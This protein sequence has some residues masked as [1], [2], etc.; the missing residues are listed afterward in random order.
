M[1]HAK[2]VK[3]A[4]PAIANNYC[5]LIGTK[6]IRV[7][8]KPKVICE[9]P[10]L[11]TLWLDTSVIIK[12]TKVERGE[13]LQQIEASQGP[14]TLVSL[15]F[16]PMTTHTTWPVPSAAQAGEPKPRPPIAVKPNQSVPL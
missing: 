9:K 12:L 4:P 7:S 15:L 16:M 2:I 8:D 3:G 14:T 11:P 1:V 13:K 10:K 6:E 5:R